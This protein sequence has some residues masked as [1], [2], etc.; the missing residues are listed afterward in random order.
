MTKAPEATND[1]AAIK[2]IDR[3]VEILHPKTREPLG[4]AVTMVS[5]DDDR[6]TKLRRRIQ[7][8]RIRLEARGKQFK[9]EDIE[10]NTSA[11]LFG[12][13]T[14]WRWYNPTGNEGDKDYDASKMP[15]FNGE[16]PQFNPRNFDA[17]ITALPWFKSQLMEA[18]SETESFFDNSK[19]S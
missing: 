17:V 4:I 11:L 2:P 18:A 16:V 5:L 12:A 3:E 8:E 15:S 13:S 14:G 1:I 6:M 10:N 19:P 9:S 7:D